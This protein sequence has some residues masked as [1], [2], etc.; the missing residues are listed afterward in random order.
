MNEDLEMRDSFGY[1]GE[2]CSS[3]TEAP[4][5]DCAWF[6]EQEGDIKQDSIG[7]GA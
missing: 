3:E 5:W 4:R 2:Q 7:R 6:K 1:L